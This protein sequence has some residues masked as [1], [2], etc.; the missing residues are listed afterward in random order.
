[1]VLIRR[2]RPPP[3]HPPA[4]ITGPAPDGSLLTVELSTGRRVLLFLTSSCRPCQEVWAALPGPPGTVVVTPSPSTES[5]RRV[6]SLAPDGTT[7]VMSSD[8]W[9]AFSPGP[10]PWRIVLEDG[11]VVAAGSGQAGAHRVDGTDDR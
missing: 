9:F 11:A 4:T 8:A 3:E 2:R 5:R 1:M 7:V 6:A 10:A